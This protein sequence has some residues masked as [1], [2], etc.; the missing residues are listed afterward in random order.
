MDY[1]LSIVTATRRSRMLA[2]GVSPRGS[3]ALLRAARAHALADGRDFLVPDDVKRLAVP[4]LAHRVLLAG[5]GAGRSR[6]GRGGGHPHD[7]AG[8]PG[9]RAER[10]GRGAGP[11]DRSGAGTRGPSRLNDPA[12]AAPGELVVAADEGHPADPRRLVVRL[13]GA[14]GSASPR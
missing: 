11:I 13:R 2:L 1:V 9:P 5:P 14:W 7:R 10:R 3:L 4:A 12:G 6:R 8:R